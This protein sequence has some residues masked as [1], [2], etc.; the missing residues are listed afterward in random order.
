[1]ASSTLDPDNF[2][3]RDRSL[4]RGH[5]TRALGPSD[6]S[7]SGSDIIGADGLA[8]DE[9]IRLDTG[10]NSDPEFSTAGHTGGPDLGDANLSADSDSSGTGETAT[11]GR[12][13][14]AEAGSDIG[15]DEIRKMSD[16]QETPQEDQIDELLDED[17]APGW[18]G[19]QVRPG[20]QAGKQ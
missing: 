1:M 13:T 12:D 2:G 9:V 3:Q 6:N 11:A 14:V 7:D 16:W 5:G 10:T 17:K 18:R 8:H 19:R 15:F 20:D 4:G